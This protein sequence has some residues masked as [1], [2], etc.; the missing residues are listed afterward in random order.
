MQ[1]HSSWIVECICVSSLSIVYLRLWNLRRYCC[2]GFP[3]SNLYFL[4]VFTRIILHNVA[5]FGMCSLAYNYPETRIMA[6]ILSLN[7][8]IVVYTY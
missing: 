6:E 3:V 4:L 1:P 2:V 8:T 7:M 5:R